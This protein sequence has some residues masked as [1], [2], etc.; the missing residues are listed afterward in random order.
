MT[1]VVTVGG[2]LRRG[3]LK[4]PDVIAQSVSIIAPGMSGGFLTYLAATKAGGATPLAYVLAAI[5][6]LFIGG[7]VSEF[8]KSMSSAGSLYT[9]TSA[10]WS[11]TAGFVVGWV[12]SLALIV[13]GAAVLA[14][15]SFFMSLFVQSLTE[16]DFVPWHWFFFAGLVFVAA[17]S[18]FNIRISTRAQL[19]LT[20]LSV[21][22]MVVAA[23][24][25]I[26]RGTPAVSLLDGTTKVAQAGKSIDLGAFW[27]SAAGVPWSGVLL[28]FAFGLL[29]FTGFEGGAVLAEE[30][31]N[32]KHNIPRAVIGSVL[33]AGVFYVLITYATSIGFGVRQA[34]TDWPLSAAGLVV[35]ATAVSSAMA[36]LVLFAV[37]VSALLCALG[38]L[39]ASS[40]F[41][42]AMGREGVLPRSLGSTHTHWKTPWTATIGTLVVWVVLNYGLLLVTSGATEVALGG[43]ASADG[44]PIFPPAVRGALFIFAY[45]ATLA[46]PAIMLAYLLLGIAGFR[47]GQADGNSRLEITGVLA[48]LTGLLAVVGSLYY[49]FKE[50]APGVGILG[51]I[52]WIPWI[53]LAVVGIG[54]AVA[55]YLRNNK[56]EAWNDMGAVFE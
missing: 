38:V 27:P 51:V 34:A 19:G 13:L 47:K 5:G 24:W 14:G 26:G 17:M 7:V 9:Y 29:S 18:L 37:A 11:K 49:S 41:L 4:L 56:Q 55:V 15:F 30:T 2:E 25:V 31:D 35:A 36:K 10:G 44:V 39:N 28:G 20:A 40:R 8:G 12:Y 6:A 48:A 50:A 52:A 21:A 46:T 16:N 22:I 45:W 32:P 42:F 54:I 23:I 43:A 1:D 3:H 53:N 33:V